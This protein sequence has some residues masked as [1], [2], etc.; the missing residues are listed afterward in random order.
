MQSC[1]T[2]NLNSTNLQKPPFGFAYNAKSNGGFD[3]THYEISSCKGGRYGLFMS[4]SIED[5]IQPK[6]KYHRA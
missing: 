5:V 3:S 6:L 1:I 2:H 4:L